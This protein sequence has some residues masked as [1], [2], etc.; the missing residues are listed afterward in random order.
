MLNICLALIVVLIVLIVFIYYI[1]NYSTQSK[2][3]ILLNTC[4]SYYYCPNVLRSS[5]NK[6]E[7]IL[8][9]HG[10]FYIKD[11]TKDKVV[12]Q[13]QYENKHIHGDTYSLDLDD[14]GILNVTKHYKQFSNDTIYE[15]TKI[16]WKSAAKDVSIPKTD[17]SYI[18]N[19]DPYTLI[20]QDNGIL[21]ITDF[22]NITIWSSVNI[23]TNEQTFALE[24]DLQSVYE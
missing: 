23:H 4:H 19:N 13:A 20:L 5:N 2:L 6:Y 14:F 11:I 15:K 3:T 9:R 22:N 24:K 18:T 10:N 16:I 12:W 8:D 17:G 7:A 21:V 1:N